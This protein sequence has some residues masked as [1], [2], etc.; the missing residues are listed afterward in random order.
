VLKKIAQRQ[1]EVILIKRR[2]IFAWRAIRLS[3]IHEKL[4]K[5]S[6]ATNNLLF[7]WGYEIKRF[8]FK[9][10]GRDAHLAQ[11]SEFGLPYT[12]IQ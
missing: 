1:E 6:F 8:Q 11:R 7:Q 3:T 10:G 12:P 4:I 5:D 9:S 2:H